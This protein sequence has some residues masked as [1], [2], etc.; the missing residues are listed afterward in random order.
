MNVLSSF[1]LEMDDHRSGS[2]IYYF[3]NTFSEFVILMNLDINQ[4]FLLPLGKG[5]EIIANVRLEFG[6]AFEIEIIGGP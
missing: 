6:N 5:W 3:G 1:F 2:H 4:M